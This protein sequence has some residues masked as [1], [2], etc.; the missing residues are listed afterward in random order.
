MK[1]ATKT[2]GEKSVIF[3]WADEQTEAVELSLFSDE[4]VRILALHGLK[5]KLGDSYSGA[6]KNNWS[7]ADCRREMHAVLAALKAGDWTRKGGSTGGIW[8]AAVARVLDKSLEEIA[9]KWDAKTDEERKAT[10]A[11]PRVKLAK[12]EIEAERAAAKVAAID[13]DD[14]EPL[15]F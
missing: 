13:S 15:D 11:D 6:E 9:P 4:I 14:A 5:Q 3:A 10:M 2:F 12:A 1:I 8:V 7:V